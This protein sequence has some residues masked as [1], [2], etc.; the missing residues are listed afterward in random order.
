MAEAD[1]SFKILANGKP[2]EK[3]IKGVSNKT[4]QLG[5]QTEATGKQM[6]SSLD[7]MKT[8]WIAVGARVA[9]VGAAMAITVQKGNEFDKMAAGLSD[10]MK[11]F[12]H[13]MAGVSDTTADIIAGMLTSAQTAGLNEDAMKGLVEQALALKAAYPLESSE[14]FNENLIMLNTSTEVQGFLV[15]I[16]EQ[17]LKAA[18]LT[19][20]D[21]DLSTLSLAQKQLLLNS[22]I[23]RGNSILDAN[24]YKAVDEAMAKWGETLTKAGD[25]LVYI[26]EKSM[27]LGLV[28][29][30]ISSLNVVVQ[31]FVGGIND[32]S[33]GW[34][35]LKALIDDTPEKL[36]KVKLAKLAV[37][38]S[39]LALANA[40]KNVTGEFEWLDKEVEKTK[41][42]IDSLTDSNTK[43]NEASQLTTEQIADL[44][45]TMLEA[46][47]ATQDFSVELD[48]VSDTGKKTADT[49]ANGFADM[50]MGVKGSFKAMIRSIVRDM[51][52]AA[53]KAR[54]LKAIAGY[55]APTGFTGDIPMG[56]TPAADLTPWHGQTESFVASG[57]GTITPIESFHGG[58][59]S[60]ERLAKLQ[61]G[62]SVINRA[63]SARNGE[64]I[65]AMN[66]GQKIGGG[67]NIQNANITFQVQAF[68]SASFQQ[69]MVQNR[70]TIVGV[71]R[72][73]FNRNGKSVA[74]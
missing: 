38:K 4:E 16:M 42:L 1:L 22:A 34:A 68:D 45:N 72:E 25:G 70:A 7:K 36:E 51:I 67:D 20:K 35:Q 19:I 6:D 24:K 5:D 17:R 40:L 46:T 13:E 59:R 12:A 65:D 27:L 39:D 44:K 47:T 73:A 57:G 33:L 43:L 74:L 63:G 50:M 49:I 61:V 14:A 55:N 3:A 64:A 2:A 48:A 32:L 23:E 56:T 9:A 31:S 37:A 66:A 15:D 58:Y 28:T 52:Y 26:A 29:K 69:G 53:A 18:G 30:V 62:E 11:D 54:I 41:V 60:D 10:S 8:S 21:I 71:V